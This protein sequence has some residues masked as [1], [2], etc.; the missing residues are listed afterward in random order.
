MK[1]FLID[2]FYKCILDLHK[3]YSV[4]DSLQDFMVSM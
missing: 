4:V 1:D 3:N 2:D